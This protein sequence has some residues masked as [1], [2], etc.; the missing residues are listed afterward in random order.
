MKRSIMVL[1]NWLMLQT[2]F[3]LKK[4]IHSTCYKINT[5][6]D[7]EHGIFTILMLVLKGAIYA[8][9]Y[10]TCHVQFIIGLPDISNT[11][12]GCIHK[13]ICYVTYLR[14]N[15]WEINLTYRVKMEYWWNFWLELLLISYLHTPQDLF[16]K[17]L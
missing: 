8:L 12:H 15:R 4:L 3:L 1:C 14:H 13:H 10:M 16:F 7:F 11:W 9:F 2:F 6:V 17:S 5:E